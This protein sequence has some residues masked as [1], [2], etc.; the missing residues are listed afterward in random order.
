MPFDKVLHKFKEGKLHS[1][2]KD[3]PVVK[4][5]KQALAIMESEKKSDKPEY[6]SKDKKKSKSM[7]VKPSAKFMEMFKSKK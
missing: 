1:G 4:S 2:S 7:N 5:K 3:G 6:K